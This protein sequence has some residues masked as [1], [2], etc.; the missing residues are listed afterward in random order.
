ML[1]IDDNNFHDEWSS[2]NYKTQILGFAQEKVQKQD[3]NYEVLGYL[4]CC[5]V[6][7]LSAI[8]SIWTRQCKKLPASVVMFWFAVGSCFW[9]VVGSLAFGQT[10]KLFDLKSEDIG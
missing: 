9:A 10:S 3:D 1:P 4:I 5:M 7:V 8:T 6:P 2:P